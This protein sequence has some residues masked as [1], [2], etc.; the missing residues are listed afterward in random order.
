MLVTGLAVGLASGLGVPARAVATARPSDAVSADAVPGAAGRLE[1]CS[2]TDLF[3]ELTAAQ[4]GAGQLHGELVLVNQGVG[5]CA[6]AG[7]PAVFQV[8]AAGAAVGEPA[9]ADGSRGRSVTLRPGG[10]ATAGLTGTSAGLVAA[11]SAGAAAAGLSVI[12]PDGDEALEVAGF[13][14]AGGFTVGEWTALRVTAF[15]PVIDSPLAVDPLAGI[16]PFT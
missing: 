12:P 6:L 2:S 13:T 14:E 1:A 11:R 8:D 7:Y 4:G 15:H 3:A 5:A 16:G 10:R 9:V